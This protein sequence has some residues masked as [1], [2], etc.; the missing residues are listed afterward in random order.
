MFII[1]NKSNYNWVSDMADINKFYRILI[2]E[3][4]LEQ[5]EHL[6]MIVKKAG[7]NMEVCSAHTYEQAELMIKNT[8]FDMFVID[9]FLGEESQKDGISFAKTVRSF[10]EYEFTPI[11][12]ITALS[13][14]LQEALNTTH[15][16]AYIKKPYSEETVLKEINNML[17]IPQEAPIL[18]IKGIH[19]YRFKILV[20]DIIFIESIKHTIIIHTEKNE[21]ITKS[22]SLKTLKALLPDY[23]Q[24][25]H[26]SYIINMMR[27]M[28]YNSATRVLLM[29]GWDYPIVV[30]RKFHE[31]FKRIG[32]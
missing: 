5:L 3:D 9:I 14:R 20:K 11:L 1:K 6:K 18:D 15:C 24:F 22:Y 7:Q 19:S 29:D 8:F 13:E 31:R 21:F 26:K 27:S 32:K 25:C 17:R 16:Y 2:L 30:A 28:S 12:Y 23:F 4:N 10:S